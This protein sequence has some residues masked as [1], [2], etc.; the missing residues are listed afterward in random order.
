MRKNV[1]WFSVFLVT[2]QLAFYSIDVAA[3]EITKNSLGQLK[4]V[5]KEIPFDI[6]FLGY[7]DSWCGKHVALQITKPD[8]HKVPNPFKGTKPTFSKFG[9]QLRELCPVVR[10]VSYNLKAPQ[11]ITSLTAIGS[12]SSN[13]YFISN[14]SDPLEGLPHEPAFECD[15]IAS[16]PRDVMRPAGTEGVLDKDLDLNQSLAI[17]LDELSL[18][19]DTPRL[20]F[21]IGRI[22]LYRGELETAA[23]YFEAAANQGHPLANVYLGGMLWSGWGV[24][25]SRRM[26]SFREDRGNQLGADINSSMVLNTY[27]AITGN[28][29][30]VYDDLGDHYKRQLAVLEM[31][32]NGLAALN[33]PN[34]SFTLCNRSGGNLNYARISTIAS[35]VSSTVTEGF[36]ELRPNECEEVHGTIDDRMVVAVAVLRKTG[37]FW[38]TVSYEV[39]SNGAV[40][41]RFD[42]LCIPTTGRFKRIEVGSVKRNECE[43]GDQEV[44]ISFHVQANSQY[45][46]LNLE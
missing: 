27:T 7:S 15:R 26:S 33:T 13:F 8:P 20:M 37:G 5:S 40:A 36:F 39:P 12:L 34:G 1:S 23:Q 45:F 38:R 19:P 24:Q 10:T 6:E 35:T 4:F 44:G 42:G 46:T 30:K 43:S 11:R 18:S 28:R 16:H 32:I 29:P 14:Q 17:C 41:H 21:A 9:Q 3:N 2:L 31:F 22:S 25:E